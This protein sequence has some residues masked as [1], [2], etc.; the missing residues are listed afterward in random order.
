MITDYSEPLLALKQEVKF[1][2][3]ALLHNKKE[4]IPQILRNIEIERDLLDFWYWKE[5]NVDK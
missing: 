5:K 3:D 2:E 4:K 1:L